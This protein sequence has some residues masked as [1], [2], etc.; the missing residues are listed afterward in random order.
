[1]YFKI[2]VR[3][4]DSLNLW[5]VNKEATIFF[6]WRDRGLVLINVMN[7]HW[8]SKL[9]AIVKLPSPYRGCSPLSQAGMAQKGAATI[10]PFPRMVK[11]AGH[12]K[13]R[14][15]YGLDWLFWGVDRR[16]HI[17]EAVNTKQCRGVYVYTV[18][19]LAIFSCCTIIRANTAECCGWPTWVDC[20]TQLCSKNVYVHHR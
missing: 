2:Q 3:K 20:V 7:D 9:T 13:V 5:Y 6:A 12:R 15:A 17:V 18:T 1:M 10:R 14:V 4:V 8:N 16:P 19:K 11:A